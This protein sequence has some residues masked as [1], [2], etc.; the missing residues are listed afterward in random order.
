MV[1]N[2]CKGSGINVESYL[3][4]I[5][6]YINFFLVFLGLN[7]LMQELWNWFEGDSLIRNAVAITIANIFI[8]LIIF[9]YR[10]YKI[11]KNESD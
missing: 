2:I 6:K 10:K 5:K 11:T 4:Y 1:M 9:L 8:N 3:N 7:F